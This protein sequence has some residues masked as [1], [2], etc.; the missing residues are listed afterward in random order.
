MVVSFIAREVTA[1]A[2]FVVIWKLWFIMWLGP[3]EEIED[4]NVK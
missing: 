2:T 4:I 3:K 1:R